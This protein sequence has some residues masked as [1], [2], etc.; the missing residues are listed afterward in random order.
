MYAVLLQKI[1]TKLTTKI[2]LDLKFENRG[3]APLKCIF[4]SK[5]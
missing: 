4:E 2:Y 3:F 1:Y 5:E